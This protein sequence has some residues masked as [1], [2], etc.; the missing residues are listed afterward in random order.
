MKSTGEVPRHTRDWSEAETLDF[1]GRQPY[2]RW[3]VGAI[4]GDWRRRVAKP[5]ALAEG[6]HLRREGVVYE[7]VFPCQQDDGVML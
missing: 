5:E 4:D 2:F 3:G 7:G 1:R 6:E